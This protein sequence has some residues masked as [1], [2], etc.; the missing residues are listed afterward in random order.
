MIPLDNY[1]KWISRLEQS[2]QLYLNDKEL[3]EFNSIQEDNRAY[4]LRELLTKPINS[5]TIINEVYFRARWGEVLKMLHPDGSLKLLEVASGDADMIPQIMAHTHPNSSYITANMNKLLN[6]SLRGKIKELPLVVEIIE[7]DAMHIEDHLGQEAVDVIAFQHSINDVLQAILCDR[8]GVDTIYSDWMETLPRMI[9]ILKKETSQGTFILHTKIPFL[10]LMNVLLKVLKKDGVIA[11][12]H[13]MF[14][15]DLDWGYPPKL[16]ENM[17]PI[18][19]E[20]MKE[21]KNCKEIFF[22]GFDPNWWI[23]LQKL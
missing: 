17:V 21:L 4:Q 8:E 19:R 23:F 2:G 7:D 6:E 20:W 22:D 13:Y 3:M 12:N 15:L 11:M 18:T 14:Q 16:F 9:E 10:G 5:F 1:D